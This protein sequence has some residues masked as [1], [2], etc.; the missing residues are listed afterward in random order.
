MRREW[1][2]GRPY[3]GLDFSPA[4]AP[5]LPRL[6]SGAGFASASDERS[7]TLWTKIT[8]IY[9][10]IYMPAQGGESSAEA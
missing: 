7:E 3:I 5:P 8:Y 6:S 10:Q 2:P 1:K 9:A 4:P